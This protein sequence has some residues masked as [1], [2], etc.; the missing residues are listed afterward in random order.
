MSNHTELFESV[1]EEQ[2]QKGLQ[3]GA[4]IGMQKERAG[5]HGG[6]EERYQNKERTGRKR[7]R[8]GKK[9]DRERDESRTGGERSQDRELL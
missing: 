9:T 7:R 2:R 5:K 6:G 8:E 4:G 3:G 1:M